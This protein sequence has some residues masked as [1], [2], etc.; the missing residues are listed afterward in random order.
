MYLERYVR[1]LAKSFY[2][3]KLYSSSQTN[4]GIHVFENQTNFS[5]IQVLFLYWLQVYHLLY[6][7][8]AQK[9]W[10]NLS[11]EVINDNIRT[12]AFLYWRQKE[13]ERELYHIKQQER[14]YKSQ[15]RKPKRGQTRQHQIF[16]GVPK[17]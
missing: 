4:N 11:E 12:D 13:Q 6:T 7:E 10:E 17:K 5:G 15:N 1:D 8:L 16:K 2:W 3:Q 9:E 14:E